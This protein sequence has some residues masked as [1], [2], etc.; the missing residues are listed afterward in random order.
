MLW[1]IQDRDRVGEATP[2]LTGGSC[3]VKV[4]KCVLSVY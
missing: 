2:V 3:L 1:W 4:G